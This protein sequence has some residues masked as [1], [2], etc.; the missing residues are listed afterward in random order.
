MRRFDLE[1]PIGSIGRY[2]TVDRGLPKAALG[3]AK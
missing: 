3:I 1:R 2:W